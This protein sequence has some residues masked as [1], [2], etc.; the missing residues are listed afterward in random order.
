M[1]DS[2]QTTATPQPTASDDAQSA[3]PSG[4]TSAPVQQ[5]VR[6][7]VQVLIPGTPPRQVVTDTVYISFSAEINPNTTES[8]IGLISN[9]VNQRVPHLYLMLSTPGG[10]VMNGMNL[11]NVMRALP[12][13]LSIH[14]VGNVDSIGNAIFLAGARRFACA[15]STFMF[16]GVG[17]NSPQGLR[18]EEKFLRERLDSIVADQQRIG[19]ILEERTSLTR[20]RSKAFSWKLRQ[21]MRHSRL[22]AGLFTRSAMSTFPQAVP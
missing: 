17:F 3:D 13:E 22:A 5:Q 21:R 9:L 16:H 10:N 15:H 1:P 4:A 7:P 6:Q 18:M 14:N 11:Y 19:S 8:L 12:C 20:D 2:P